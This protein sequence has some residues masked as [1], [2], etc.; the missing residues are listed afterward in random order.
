MTVAVCIRCGRM[1]VGAFTQCP[2]CGFI[3]EQAEDMARSVMLSD[4]ASDRPALEDAGEKLQAGM[5]LEFDEAAVREWAKAIR[6]TSA[7]TGLPLGC[8]VVAY[9]PFVIMF[10]L[11]AAMIG[12]LAYAWW[13]R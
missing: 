9:A 5:P 10:V 7:G 13:I 4:Q 1:K 11:I 2:A 6:E 12:L 8:V 3:P